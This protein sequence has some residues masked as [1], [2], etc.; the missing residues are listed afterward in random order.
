M[1]QR[2]KYSQTL[3]ACYVPA[4]SLM[5]YSNFRMKFRTVLDLNK[6]DTKLSNLSVRF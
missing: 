1:S 3:L 2:L 5:V 6:I 4:V